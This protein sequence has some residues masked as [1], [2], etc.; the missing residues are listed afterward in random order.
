MVGKHRSM[1][2]DNKCDL[3][4]QQA[5]LTVRSLIQLTHVTGMPLVAAGVARAIVA[6]AENGEDRLRYV[7]LETLCEL[8]ASD[9]S[10]LLCRK[11]DIWRRNF[12][13]NQNF[14]FPPLS[15][16]RCGSARQC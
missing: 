3:E 8:G 13:S 5:L 1:T 7:A 12:C 15:C 10:S 6:L 11:R 9:E 2:R 4:K 14:G 16:Q